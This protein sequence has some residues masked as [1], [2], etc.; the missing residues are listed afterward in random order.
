[1]NFKIHNKLYEYLDILYKDI[2]PQPLDEGHQQRTLEV[3]EN[4]IVPRKKEIKNVIDIGCGQGNACD[5]FKQLGIKWQ[6]ITAGIIDYHECLCKG[7]PVKRRDMSFTGYAHNK[8]DLIFAR[9]VLEH[10]P[11]PLISLMEWYRIGKKY[12]VVVVPNPDIEVVGG[13]NH[14]YMLYPPQWSVLF[15]NS[16]WLFEAE[17]YSCPEEFRFLLRKG[18]NRVDIHNNPIV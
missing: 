10:S 13:R 3:I 4:L 9:H 14:Y 8:F 15:R 2:Y 5:R 17:D 16:G 7:M 18:K 11:M 6:G 1:M 12:L